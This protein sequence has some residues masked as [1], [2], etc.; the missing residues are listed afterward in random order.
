MSTN[1]MSANVIPANTVLVIPYLLITHVY[2]MVIGV[3]TSR[4]GMVA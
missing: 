3:F 2:Y 4:P 1:T